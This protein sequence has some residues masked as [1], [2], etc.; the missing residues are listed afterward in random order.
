MGKLKQVEPNFEAMVEQ[1]RFKKRSA[2]FYERPEGGYYLRHV[3]FLGTKPPEIKG[4]ADAAFHDDDRTVT[5]V[6]FEEETQMDENTLFERLKAWAKETFGQ[7]PAEPAAAKSFSED[8]AKKLVATAVAEATKPLTDQITDLKAKLDQQ[9]K[10]FS[11]KPPSGL[12]P[13]RK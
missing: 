6:T 8:D 7:K 5:E 10:D 11:Q 1:G 4:L 9:A 13:R 3:G 12:S 2:S